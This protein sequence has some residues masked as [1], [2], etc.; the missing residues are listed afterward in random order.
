[1][2]D[3]YGYLLLFN[4]GRFQIC[5]EASRRVHPFKVGIEK[6]KPGLTPGI[7]YW[8]ETTAGMCLVKFPERKI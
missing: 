2:K 8:S 3:T 7:A 1:M 6:N 5:I 4:V